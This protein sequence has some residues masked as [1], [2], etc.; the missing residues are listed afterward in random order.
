MKKSAERIAKERAVASYRQHL[1]AALIVVVHN[2][3]TCGSLDYTTRL[4]M[5]RDVT[6]YETIS[7]DV[8]ARELR[9][10]SQTSR[11]PYLADAASA[12]EAFVAALAKL[13]A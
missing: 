11:T 6:A 12:Y 8:A 9:E 10:M 7:P 5:I 2:I 13:E 4:Q 1:N 3:V